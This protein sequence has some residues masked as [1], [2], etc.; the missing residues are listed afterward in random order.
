MAKDVKAKG[1]ATP[2]DSSTP[3]QTSGTQS[4]GDVKPEPG[5]PKESWPY[6]RVQEIAAQR[7]ETIQERDQALSRIK[8]LEAQVAG[9][10]GEPIDPMEDPGRYVQ[11][12]NAALRTEINKLTER[13]TTFERESAGKAAMDERS[14]EFDR[15]IQQHPSLCREPIRSAVERAWMLHLYMDPEADTG[16][17]LA[18]EVTLGWDEVKTPTAK[19]EARRE[20]LAGKAESDELKPMLTKEERDESLKMSPRDRTNHLLR[21]VRERLTEKF[22]G[23]DKRTAG[24]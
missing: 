3:E 24:L 23:S 7:K 6:K 12:E 10:G 13:I 2:G 22:Y 21:R 8:E 11:Q 9:S 16:E 14:R 19:A 1:E 5:A 20:S 15:L 18:H 17:W 4:T